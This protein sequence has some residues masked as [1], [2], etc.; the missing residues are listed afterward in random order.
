MA[1][2]ETLILPALIPAAV[3]I[4][5]TSVGRLVGVKAKT[6]EEVIQLRNS[7]VEKLKAIAE[8]DRPIGSPSQWVVDL[9][10]SFRYILAGISIVASVTTLYIPGVPELLIDYSWQATGAIFSFLFGEH[11]VLNVKNGGSR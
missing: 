11:L 7:E 2:L 5:K 9:R 10:A 3:D 1:I 8:L 4:L 6:V